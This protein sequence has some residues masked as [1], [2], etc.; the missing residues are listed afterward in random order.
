M[1][2][3]AESHVD[4]SIDS[5]EVFLDTNIY[6]TYSLESSLLYFNDFCKKNKFFISTYTDEVYG[7]LDQSSEA[8]TE[9]SNYDPSSPY[10][11]QKLPQII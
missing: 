8:F 1:Y 11:A 9:S 5:P 7:S 10:S 4:R 6:G 3:A 2:E